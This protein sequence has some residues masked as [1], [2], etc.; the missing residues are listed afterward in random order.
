MTTTEQPITRAELRE[1]F[2]RFQGELREHYATKADLV[3]ETSRIELKIERMTWT[4]LGGMVAVGGI[5]VGV[6]KLLE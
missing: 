5:V 6:L 4:L 1:E 2:Q 3:R